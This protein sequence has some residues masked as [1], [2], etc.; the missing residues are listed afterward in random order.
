MS[1]LKPSF[2]EEIKES[3]SDSCFTLNDFNL[4]LPNSG[5]VFLNLIFK[6]K[7]EYKLYVA[8]ETHTENVKVTDSFG[9]NTHTNKNV[10]VVLVAYITP[11]EYKLKEQTELSSFHEITEIIPSWC[12]QIKDDLYSLVPKPDPVESIRKEFEAQFENI[13]DPESYFTAEEKKAVD[14][15]F[16]ELF[17]KFEEL[18]E[19]YSI[20]K[21]QL[22]SIRDEFEEFKNSSSA[23]PKGVWAKITSNKLVNIVSSVFKSPEGRKFILEQFKNLLPLD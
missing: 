12:R 13:N 10:S 4:D 19:E 20:S 17:K 6:H 8:E 2:I 14:D 11:G 16:D 18:K 21:S 22:H 23:Y 1:Q 5:E 7:P 15:R 3:I 9:L